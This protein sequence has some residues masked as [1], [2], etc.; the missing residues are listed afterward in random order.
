MRN[1][2]QMPKALKILFVHH[3][4]S[5]GG[6]ELSLVDLTSNLSD[7]IHPVSAVPNGPLSQ[8]LESRKI[9]TFI[10]PMRPLVKSVNP[11][12]WLMT[13]FNCLRI[14][15]ELIGI[16]RKEKVKV[17]HAN[18]LTAC[19]YAAPV[20]F[21]CRIPLIWHERDLARHPFLTPIIA[22]FAKRIIAI[23]NAVAENLKL[24]LGVNKK[25]RMIYN[26]ID[27]ERFHHTEPAGVPAFPGLPA[28]KKIV[29]MAAQFVRWKRHNDFI[30]MA[31]YV[32]EKNPDAFFVLA[33]DRE[34]QAQQKYVRELESSI[35]E[36]G[37][38]DHFAWTGYVVDMPGLLQNADC[39]VL[40]A[41]REPFG[42]IV[43]EAMAAGKPVVSVNSGAIPEIIEDNVSGF[44]CE[45]GD[46]R[47]MAEAVCRLLRDGELSR[48]IGENGYLR[49]SQ[50]FSIQRTV[51]EFEQLV[52]GLLIIN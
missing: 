21:L 1:G 17:I 44:V 45:P 13:G 33:G 11:A 34:I 49:I 31:S 15:F 41:E 18:S 10:V 23:S 42:R 43:A 5:K 25:I 50:K 48:K 29:L 40:P 7:E 19:I 46:C 6:A 28:G 52:K 35:V 26:G 30:I 3:N 27:V 24:E 20:S 14:V 2:Q 16:C 37:L 9:P 36:K 51:R 38:K 32:R 8:S 4:S 47:A 12:Y 22:K 39:V